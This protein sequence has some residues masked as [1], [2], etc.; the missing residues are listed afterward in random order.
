MSTPF[1]LAFIAIL[2]NP[3]ACASIRNNGN[4]TYRHENTVNTLASKIQKVKPALKNCLNYF[5]VSCIGSGLRLKLLN[6]ACHDKNIF[7]GKKLWQTII[8]IQN[9]FCQ[10]KHQC[11]EY[12]IY[13]KDKYNQD[14]TSTE[15]R[16]LCLIASK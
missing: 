3:H 16:T 1:N 12:Y 13:T 2:L 8:S 5:T 11:I 9:M 4:L 10:R 14:K 7:D 6:T 15:D